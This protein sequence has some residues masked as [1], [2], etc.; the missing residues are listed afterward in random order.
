MAAKKKQ[1]FTVNTR[2][3]ILG[4][5]IALIAILIKKFT[6]IRLILM[7]IAIILVTISLVQKNKIILKHPRHILTIF[8][9]ILFISFLIDT[10][11]VYTL[12]RIPIYTLSIISTEK[13]RV[14]NGIG[15]RVWQCNKDD[16]N[17]LIVD[18]FNSKGYYCDGE[19][20]E[21]ID[22]NSFLN[23]V[24]ENYDDYKNKFVKIRGKISSKTSRNSIEMK[25]YT[26][27]EITVNGYVNFA[28][29]ITLVILFNDEEPKLDNY[30]VYDEILVVGKIKN[31]E[32][33]SNGHVIYMSD[34]KVVSSESYSTYTITA[35]REYRC[36]PQSPYIEM[37]DYHVYTYCLTP[38]INVSFNGKN[39]ELASA[40]SSGKVTIK[41]IL[42]KT[43]TIE[44]D[45][46]GNQIY[47][48]NNYNIVKCNE[49]KSMDIIIASSDTKISDVVCSLRVIDE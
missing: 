15:Y 41:D 23:A 4:L 22:S 39:Y 43:S 30:D 26:E 40:L 16:Y 47:K 13:T 17:N 34:S 42:S 24:I 7:I 2:I 10:I 20:I 12:S 27:N 45:E 6:P 32:S 1:K 37:D 31:I 49:E 35:N 9:A 46:N 5:I 25:P 19:D 29:N 8:L 3:L 33:T 44:E 11:A 28:D 48:Y 14:Y 36:T 21:E 38:D 18:V